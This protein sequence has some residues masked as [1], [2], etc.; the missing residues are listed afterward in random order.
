[1]HMAAQT[2]AERVEVVIIGAG[3][4]GLAVSHELQSADVEHVILER[5]RVGESW[6]KRWE[7]F[8]L[9]TPNWTLELPGLAYEGDEPN[10]FVHRDE[11]VA[12]VVKY[13]AMLTAPI[14]EG[15]DVSSVEPSAE[16]RF[17]LMLADG[18]LEANAVVVAAGAYRKT[19]RPAVASTLPADVNVIDADGYTRPEDLP[20]GKVLV[21]GSGQTGCQIAEEL[22][23][24]GREVVLSCG[25]APWGPRRVDG[26]DIVS[27][28]AQTPFLDHTVADLPHPNARLGA[29]FQTTGRGGGHDLHY[30]TLQKAGVTLTGRIA[31]VDD[32]QAVFADDLAESVAFGDARYADISNLIRKTCVERGEVPPE[33]PEPKPFDAQPPERM[34]LRDC[35]AVIFTSG[36][37]PDYGDWVRFPDAF[38]ELGFPIQQDGESSVAPG[39][40]FIGTHFLRKRKSATFM[41]ALEDAPIVAERIV[42]RLR[43]G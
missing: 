37:R 13:A 32:R 6:R 41:G 8:C 39:L 43:S 14:R 23:E 11:I 36:F 4:A 28:V 1:M 18:D 42:A 26:R 17:R 7:N 20:S 22:N 16:G 9:V 33:F 10:G 29:N 12:H 3:H 2:R 31:T 25:R 30:R 40:F 21:V 27:W 35:G 38:D 5:D 24:S 19:H 15:V 34:N